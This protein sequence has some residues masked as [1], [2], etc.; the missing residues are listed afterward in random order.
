MITASEVFSTA[1]NATSGTI[2]DYTEGAT[3]Q[4]ILTGTGSISCVVILKVSL[5]KV[6]WTNF[7]ISHIEGTNEASDAVSASAAWPYYQVVVS[8][9]S[10]TISSLKA[11][12]SN[13]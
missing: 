4:F 10:G 12:C 11:L 7:S 3:F 13:I 1:I 9:C 8:D 6:H 2:T 5:D